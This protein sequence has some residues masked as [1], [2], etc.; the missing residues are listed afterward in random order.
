MPQTGA[1]LPS[2]CCRYKCTNHEWPLTSASLLL[3]LCCS[4]FCCAQAELAAQ[5]AAASDAELEEEAEQLEVFG[6][7]RFGD[8]T[9]D[10]VGKLQDAAAGVFRDRNKQQAEL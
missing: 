2:S 4:L 6:D 7:V 1:W 10:V 8:D 9:R 3:L 5:Q